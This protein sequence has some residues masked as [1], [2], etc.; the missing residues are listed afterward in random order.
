MSLLYR[1]RNLFVGCVDFYLSELNARKYMRYPFKV[2]NYELLASFGS[3]K[4]TAEYHW[5]GHQVVG[6]ASGHIYGWEI[7]NLAMKDLRGEGK[8]YA[9]ARMLLSGEVIP[10]WKVLAERQWLN[11]P[12]HNIRP[13]NLQEKVQRLVAELRKYDISSR[14]KLAE[15]ARSSTH[16]LEKELKLWLNV[17]NYEAVYQT[18]RNGLISSS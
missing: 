8:Y 1:Q 3:V 11:Y 4:E 17:K 6:R 5:D 12:V 9:F 15:R 2:V 14:E 18:L 7:P 16:F 13:D 10:S